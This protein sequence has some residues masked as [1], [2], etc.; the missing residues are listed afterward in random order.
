MVTAKCY[1]VSLVVSHSRSGTPSPGADITPPFASEST[2]LSPYFSRARR[3]ILTLILLGSPCLVR[4]ET[5]A[6]SCARI[7]E[8][9]RAPAKLPGY[10]GGSKP[11]KV[12]TTLRRY[13]DEIASLRL[14]FRRSLLARTGKRVQP[15]AAI[16]DDS[17][18]DNY[19]RLSSSTRS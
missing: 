17:R 6:P 7:R 5:S 12:G 16:D 9:L 13:S 2:K 8:I 14:C 4:K 1:D 11:R 19:K 3:V 10:D 15:T 18:A